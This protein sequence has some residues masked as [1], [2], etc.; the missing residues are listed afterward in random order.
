MARYAKKE[1]DEQTKWDDKIE[2]AKK[3]RKNW[4]ERFKVD[5]CVDYFEGMQNPGYPDEEWLTINKFYSNLKTKLPG[6]YRTDPY[7]YVR[8]KRSYTPD[9]T[10]IAEYEYKAKTRQSML[11]YYK[12]EQKLKSKARLCIQDAQFAYGVLKSHYSADVK[13]NPDAGK[14]IYLEQDEPEGMIGK[15]GE[16]VAPKP[17]VQL[18]D[19]DGETPLVEPDFIPVHERYN[20]TRIHPKDFLFDEDAGPLEDTWTWRAQRI[21][22]PMKEAKK[23]K[24]FNQ[25]AIKS[26]DEK[27]GSEDKEQKI[28]E[29]RKK[30]S[31]VS[32]RGDEDHAGSKKD[33]KKEKQLIYWEIYLIKENRWLCIAEGAKIPL[34]SEEPS[35]EG[36]DGDPF[37]YLTFTMRDDS[38]YPIPPM[39]Q[40]LDLQK[41]FNLTRS[42]LMVHRKRFNRKYEVLDSVASDDGE[43]SKLESGE[44]GTV[45]RVPMLG[46]IGPIKDAPLDQ[47]TTYAEFNIL[48]REINEA[49]GGVTDEAR[50][51]A[52]ADS[53][54]QAGIME[55]HFDVR[56]GD[57]VALVIDFI[58]EAAKKFDQLIQANISK[59]EAVYITGPEGEFWW[60]VKE[61]D[62]E[63]ILGE[64]EYTVNVGATLPNLPQVERSS[65]MAFLGILG[66]FPQLAMS[67]RLL[68]KT[69]EMH[70]LEDKSMVDEI[71]KIF[72]QMMQQRQAA[73]QQAAAD[74]A[75]V[76]VTKPASAT[77]GVASGHSSLA[78]P[79]AGNL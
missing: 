77:A 38:P 3:V 31:E 7:F 9:P 58:Q 53:A 69:A 6:L 79:G 50:G 61:E 22:M 43:L 26:I 44:D 27:G 21:V 62:Y 46:A 63:E 29:E 11:N 67:K 76:S 72:Q 78:L 73:E 15:L 13:E 41:E 17:P 68:Q 54:T 32:G 55:S 64:Y 49:L 39:S 24:R 20:W 14:P 34:I 65:W 33:A 71:H 70:H 16:M 42:R 48:A 30:G 10:L 5:L 52:T 8:P 28:R 75:G 37:S 4:E 12:G 59:D 66:Q 35:P 2:R 18:Y 19:D 45:I 36:V 40:G 51:I 1:S 47:Q 25:A 74:K 56:E 57:D 23:D 60:Q